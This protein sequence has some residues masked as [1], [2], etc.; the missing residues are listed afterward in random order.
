MRAPSLF[1]PLVS[2]ALALG[3]AARSSTGD[4]VLVLLDDKLDKGDYSGFFSSLESECSSGRRRD[5]AEADF[6]TR[7]SAHIL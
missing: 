7:V 2:L 1:A 5:V 6:R 4:R 3:V